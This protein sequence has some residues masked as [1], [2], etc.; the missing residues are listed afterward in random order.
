MIVSRC[1]GLGPGVGTELDNGLGTVIGLDTVMGLD[2]VTGLDTV[3]LDTVGLGN[4][5]RLG[6]GLV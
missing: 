1:R 5:T 4:D 6:S 3:G 2:T